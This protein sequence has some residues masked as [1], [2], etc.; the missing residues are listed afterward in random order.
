MSTRVLLP[1]RAITIHAH[2]AMSVV[3][4]LTMQPSQSH[5]ASLL[6]DF[7]TVRVVCQAANRCSATPLPQRFHWLQVRERI[8]YKMA[9][10]AFKVKSTGQPEYLQAFSTPSARLITV[11]AAIRH[12]KADVSTHTHRALR[13]GLQCGRAVS[14]ERFAIQPASIHMIVYIILTNMYTIQPVS[15]PVGQRV[16]QPIVC[17]VYT[18]QSVVQ[19]VGILYTRRSRLS[20]PL[21]NPLSNRLHQQS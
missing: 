10:L 2:C 14:V 21:S 8:Q 13:G 11:A 16:V 15:Q 3:C 1:R 17:S 6:R 12:A 7:T 20:N 9:L 5:A 19:T 18:M 4:C